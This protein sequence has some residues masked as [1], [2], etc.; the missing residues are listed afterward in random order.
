ML[1]KGISFETIKKVVG[2]SYYVQEFAK[3]YFVKGGSNECVY[4]LEG[5]EINSALSL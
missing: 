2:D 5:P 3:N 4:D 1:H